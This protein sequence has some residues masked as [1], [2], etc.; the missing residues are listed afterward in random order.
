MTKLPDANFLAVCAASGAYA[1]GFAAGADP[2]RT[3]RRHVVDAA[4]HAHW[5][6]G[7]DDG[8]AAAYKADD[9]YTARLMTEA[10]AAAEVTS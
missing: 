7:Y 8:R 5:L 10:R 2:R 3:R 9:A 6:R 1:R 4:T